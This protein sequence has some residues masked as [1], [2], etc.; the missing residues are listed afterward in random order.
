MKPLPIAFLWHMH[1]PYYKDDMSGEYLLP[2][3]RNHAQ[4]AYL[5]MISILDEFPGLKMT[6]NLSPSLLTQIE[7]YEKIG[8]AGDLF[9]T[10]SRKP[11]SELDEQE[12][13]FLLRKF[14]MCSWDTMIKSHPGYWSLLCK[15]GLEATPENI[16]SADSSFSDGDI[17]DVQVWFNL[18][19]FG[20]TACRMYPEID[21]L[22]GKGMGFTEE[23]KNR[24]LDIQVELLGK[25][26][27]LYRKAADEG[28]IEISTN[29]FY[30]PILPLLIDNRI[31]RRPSPDLRLPSDFSAP[32]DAE[33]QIVKALDL[34][35]RLFEKR[36]VGMWPSEGSVCPELIP[37]LEGI[38]VRWMATDEGILE[39]TLK[40]TGAK[41]KN[42][43]T[44]KYRLYVAE[45]D[46]RSVRVVFRDRGLSDRIGFTYAKNTT[47]EALEDLFGHLRGIAEALAD[48]KEPALV[49]IFLD[50]ENPWEY[51]PDRGREFLREMYERFSESSE[52]VLTDIGSY[53]EANPSSHRLADLYSGSWIGSNFNIWIGKPEANSAWDAIARTRAFLTDILQRSPQITEAKRNESWEEIYRAEGSDWFWWYDDDF[54]SEN[55]PEFDELFR[56]HLQNTYRILGHE[57]PDDL[58]LPISLQVSAEFVVQPLGLMTPRID[59]GTTHF[60]EWGNAGYCE[61]RKVHPS[62]HRSSTLL[63][64]LFFGFDLDRFYLRLDPPPLRGSLLPGLRARL[65]FLEPPGLEINFPFSFDDPDLHSYDLI[66]E[67]S[68]EAQRSVQTL[69]SIAS[70]RVIELGIA[71]EKL[72]VSVGDEVSFLLRILDGDVELECY[73][74]NGM[75]S[76]NVPD[77]G[78]ENIMWTV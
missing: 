43:G 65:N 31:A 21:E 33:A 53:L 55:D 9:L 74:A 61:I 3:V 18:C 41:A 71:F 25:V 50:G 16:R 22:R 34:H 23:E 28:R 29:P 1:Q 35:E 70:G 56:R 11:A 5:D 54:Y 52:F 68:G 4:M 76:F 59:G 62:M 19:W 47:H 37:M 30:H 77:A 32:A 63:G 51:Y 60:Y 14:F 69:E 45:A 2:W 38:G 46:D 26:L 15:R 72:N 64:G 58:M 49:G 7:D 17:L 44:A 13:Q 20:H 36:P 10:L 57:V 27:P 75:I 12:R 48:E 24:L 8:G 40:A 73:P 6:F 78:Y 67:G 66:R 42:R 39:N